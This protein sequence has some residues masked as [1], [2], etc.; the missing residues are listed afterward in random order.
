MKTL[1]EILGEELYAMIS[2]RKYLLK[3]ELNSDTIMKGGFL[4]GQRHRKI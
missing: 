2:M 1:K 4:H 3:F